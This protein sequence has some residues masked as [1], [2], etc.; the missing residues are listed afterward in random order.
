M[1]YVL[2]LGMLKLFKKQLLLLLLPAFLLGANLD[3]T[4]MQKGEIGKDNVFLLIGGIQGDEPGGFLAA[5][6]IGTK[7]QITKGS[8]WIVPNLNFPSIISRS[9]GL[10]GDMNRKFANIDTSDPDYKAVKLIKD[11]IE[12]DL[13]SLVLNLHDGSGFYRKTY[14]NKYFNPYRWGNS[15]IIDQKNLEGVK[16]GDLAGIAQ[17]VVGSINTKLLKPVHQYHVKNTETALG[18]KEMLKSLTFYAISKGKA[19]FANE[20]SKS[21]SAHMR[22]YYHLLAIEEYMRIMGI[23]FV[24]NFEMTPEGVK[25]AINSDIYVTIHDKQRIELDNTRNVIN[26]VPMPKGSDLVF[27]SSNPLTTIVKDDN[28]YYSVY[29]GNR[30]LTRLIPQYFN[31]NEH[32]DSVEVDIDG[33]RQQIKFGSVI[34]VKEYFSV[35]PQDGIRVNV[36][37]YVN[38]KHK[39]ESGLNIRKKYILK[40]YSIDKDENIFRVEIYDN[41]KKD[42]FSGMFL[43]EFGGLDQENMPLAMNK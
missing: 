34:K 33:Q 3:V 25:K 13:V 12:N 2:S 17:R 36:I 9:R 5:S 41:T 11:L 39:N 16:Y 22:V 42:T 38:K 20:A 14:I 30:R 7:Y 35:T 10:S 31:Y 24:R 32:H 8:V 19:A 21:L 23:E 4:L 37:G 40:Q 43:V 15:C 28:G 1:E 26:Y 29:Y 27:E 6:L 18:D